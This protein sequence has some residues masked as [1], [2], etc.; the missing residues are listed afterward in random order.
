M[1]LKNNK[2]VF[3]MPTHNNG[4][5]KIASL[6]NLKMVRTVCDERSVEISAVNL[7]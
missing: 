7:T 4:S 2:N 6:L 1:K 5:Q 3:L